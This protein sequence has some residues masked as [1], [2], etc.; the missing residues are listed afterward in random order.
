[1]KPARFAMFVML[2]LTVGCILTVSC[3]KES[4]R[5]K[6]ASMREGSADITQAQEITSSTA[7]PTMTLA[8]ILPAD[9]VSNKPL[10]VRYAGSD[11]KGRPI[12][13][14]F[15]WYIDGR[16]I[17]EASGDKLEPEFFHKGDRVEAEVIPT[18]GKAEGVPLRTV[19]VTIKNTPPSVTSVELSPMMAHV[20]DRITA[21]PKGSDWDGDSITYSYQWEVD[22]KKV[23]GTD[24]AE[25]DTSSLKKKN[26]ITVDVTPSD[27][28]DLGTPVR[29]EKSVVLTNRPP[30]ITSIPP[31]ELENGVFIYRV[32]AIDPDGD[33]LTYRLDTS[34]QGMT[35]D[36]STG[37]VRWEP[38]KEV[39]GKQ[40]TRVKVIVDDGDGGIAYQEFSL[41]TEMR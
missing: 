16:L 1:M 9:P 41:F 22:G 13:Y 29:S 33:P 12:V 34:P 26:V 36:S 21:S 8:T 32:T 7:V 6:D 24:K 27:G 2:S 31:S 37:V 20:G 11:P 23:P 15:R 25:F 30:T 38:P 40:E 4:V 19:A 3:T 10:S 5:Q 18:I 14:R 17:P 35:I 39:I 28:E